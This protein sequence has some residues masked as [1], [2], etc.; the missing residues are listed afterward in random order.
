MIPR[1]GDDAPPPDGLRAART[2]ARADELL[3]DAAL[4]TAQKLL[5]RPYLVL[6][7]RSRPRRALARVQHGVDG[8]S[9]SASSPSQHKVGLGRLPGGWVLATGPKNGW[10][11]D[12]KIRLFERF[13][14][15]TAWRPVLFHRQRDGVGRSARARFHSAPGDD[16]LSSLLLGQALPAPE[17]SLPPLSAA[18]AAAKRCCSIYACPS[19]V[20]GQPEGARRSCRAHALPPARRTTGARGSP[21]ARSGSW[22]LPRRLGLAWLLLQCSTMWQPLPLLQACQLDPFLPPFHSALSDV[23]VRRT[24]T[25]VSRTLKTCRRRTCKRAA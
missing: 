13:G 20:W 9:S 16:E 7:G 11:Q 19:Q 24:F 8:R 21:A 18:P 5:A 14:G 6:D 1:R 25:D 2:H 10:L 17:L 23:L 22:W 3:G 12:Q 15:R 4:A